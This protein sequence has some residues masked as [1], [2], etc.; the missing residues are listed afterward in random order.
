L[1][2]NNIELT[3]IGKLSGIW[4]ILS[5]GHSITSSEGYTTTCEL[6][7]IIPGSVSGSSKTPKVPVVKKPSYKVTDVINRDN[8]AFPTLKTL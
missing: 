6:K 2:G 7:R 4:N 1:A 5:A 8:I 3:G